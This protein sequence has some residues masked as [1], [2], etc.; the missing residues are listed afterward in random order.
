MNHHVATDL[1]GVEVVVVDFHQTYYL[2]GGDVPEEYIEGVVADVAEETA[3]GAAPGVDI[4]GEPI[5]H[6]ESDGA[7]ERDGEEVDHL[8]GIVHPVG[9]EVAGGEYE[10]EGGE[11]HRPAAREE[12]LV[13]AEEYPDAEEE[14]A[15]GLAEAAV[16]DKGDFEAV[17]EAEGVEGYYEEENHGCG[18]DAGEAGV[19][20]EQPPQDKV[21]DGGYEEAAEEPEG[22]GHEFVVAGHPEEY[23]DEAFHGVVPG[24]GVGD[25]P[26]PVAVLLVE[27]TEIVPDVVEEQVYHTPFNKGD[28]EAL[29]TFVA[30]IPGVVHRLLGE[31]IA[32]GDEEEGHVEG[33]K[34]SYEDGGAFGVAGHH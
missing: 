2:I 6:Q 13:T 28:I 19:A 24:I 5:G 8:A 14:D 21:A 26:F 15:P 34:E 20:F 4:A 12:R 29:E 1:G 27:D 33:I 16:G 22:A 3:E 9:V 7:G 17:G 11:Q 18:A 32:G 31:E 10:Q 23:P 30:E 25:A